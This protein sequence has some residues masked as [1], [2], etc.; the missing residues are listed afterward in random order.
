MWSGVRGADGG[1]TDG[2]VSSTSA[3]RSAATDAR[4]II[5]NMKVAI[6]TDM[7]IWIR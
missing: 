3:M 5:M 2:S 1:T 4:G 6:M 7:R